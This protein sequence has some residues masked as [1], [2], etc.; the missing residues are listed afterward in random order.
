M[1]MRLL[2]KI[3]LM[4]LALTGGTAVLAEQDQDAPSQNA[5]AQ[6]EIEERKKILVMV[7]QAPNRLRP[8]STYSSGYGSAQTKALRERLGRK[9]AEQHGFKF[10]E[11]WP[12]PLLGLDCFVI[13]V[14]EE[15]SM[16]KA[17]A[18]L[19]KHPLVEWAETMEVYHTLAV[20]G[21]DDPLTALSPT[22]NAWNLPKLHNSW[23]GR[24][25]SVA[26]ID[27]QVDVNHP[28]LRG[29]IRLSRNFAPQSP[30]RPEYHG[31]EVAGI[32]A[33]NAGNGIGIA[34]V[35]PGARVMALRACWQSGTSRRS[36]CTSLNLARAIN[37]AIERDAKII[38]LSL[39][40]PQNRLLTNLLDV[41]SKRGIA[42]VAAYD[43][44]LPRGGFPASH[45]NVIAVAKSGVAI[46]KGY[47][48]PGIDIPT[49]QPG[50]GWHFVSGSS[51]SAAHVTGLLALNY[52]RN[53]TRRGPW[54]SL[55]RTGRN[56]REIDVPA[57]FQF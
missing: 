25:V 16:A 27:T 35:A 10:V 22:K 17:K 3:A 40:G 5:A 28:D 4:L 32:I 33:A 52:E 6:T 24:N 57:T 9:I 29:R 47:V 48:A 43:P 30:S 39:G 23:T 44:R 49:T 41:A 21:R 46:G 36:S 8:G 18:M 1:I 11:F 15:Q 31:T 53:R 14:S 34:G 54:K 2:L 51:Y 38:N 7:K 12:M 19:E 37:Y 50:G 56:N 42:I 13:E 45:S 26:V 55:A 20:V